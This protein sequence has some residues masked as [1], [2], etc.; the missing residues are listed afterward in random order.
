MKFP[1]PKINLSV[2]DWLILLICSIPALYL[3]G[4]PAIY[5]WDEAVYANASWEMAHGGSWWIP[6]HGEYN[7]KPPLVLWMQAIA[8]KLLPY[9]EWAVRLPSALAVTGILFMLQAALKRWGFDLSTRF[10]VM[11]CFVA[12]EGFIRH[13]I[14]RTGDLDAVMT[15]FVTAYA[16]IVLDALVQHRW[17]TK[18]M[19]WFFMMMAGAFYSKSIGGWLMMGPI[20]IVWVLSPMRNVWLRPR[21]WIAGAST[22]LV[23]AM[24]Y[25]IRESGQP[26]FMDL[27]WAS[28]YMRMFRNVMPW[29]EHGASYYFRNFQQLH[30]YT[31]WIFALVLAVFIALVFIKTKPLK[32]L[33]LRWIILAAGFL[34]VITIPAVKL[35]WYD[36]PVY[37]WFALILGTVTGWALSHLPQKARWAI[38]LPAAF[39]FW[40]KLEF[41]SGDVQPRHPF[42]FEGAMLRQIQG[43][44]AFK[45]YMKVEHPEHKLQLDFYQKSAFVQKGQSIEVVDTVSQLYPGD[46]VLISQAQGISDIA[47]HFNIDTLRIWPGLGYEFKLEVLP[48]NEEE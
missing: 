26:G 2:W 19:V 1:F 15:F 3:L 48:P 27:A 4:R 41:I 24:Y 30:T 22:L 17:T 32:Y 18:H 38:V 14:S 28:E 35:E 20:A 33:V 47:Q 43:K 21:F 44:E 12:N 31:P 11:I 8:L 10:C 5:I 45:V 7:T 29:H 37:P 36:A 46:H 25:L 34:M 13:H 9:P 40:H 42:E 23:C 39:L 6:T 16:L